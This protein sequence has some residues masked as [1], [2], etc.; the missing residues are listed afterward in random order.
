MGTACKVEADDDLL[1]DNDGNYLVTE[2]DN[3]LIVT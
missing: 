1:T 3:K 2:D